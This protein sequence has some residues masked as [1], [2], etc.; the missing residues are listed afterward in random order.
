[1]QPYQRLQGWFLTPEGPAWGAMGGM[2]AGFLCVMGLIVGRSRFTGWPF[3]PIGFAVSGGWSM[4]CLWL[5]LLIA[6]FLK[7]IILRYGQAKLYRAALP[8]FLGLVLGEFVVGSI[9]TII[10]IALRIPTYGFWV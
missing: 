7:T 2:V 3:H 8:F 1:M 10:G 5:P 4:N 6:W 9:W